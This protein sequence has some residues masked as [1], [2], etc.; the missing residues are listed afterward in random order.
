M[1]ERTPPL[2]RVRLFSENAAEAEKARNLQIC[3]AHG[4][5]HSLREIAAAAGMSHEK[6]RRILGRR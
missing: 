1:S 5:G 6:V 2:D 4:H 3:E